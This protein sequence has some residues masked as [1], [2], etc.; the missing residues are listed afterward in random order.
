MDQRVT[1]ITFGVSDVARAR[2]F[3][4]RIGWKASSESNAFV[5]FFQA[6]TTVFGLFGQEMLSEES[7]ISGVPRP[8]GVSLACNMRSREEVDATMA[9]VEAAG[10]TI[11]RPA[12]ETAWGGYVG[13]FTDP[14]GHAWEVTHAPMLELS[15]DGFL[16]MPD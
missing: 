7:G 11:T 9:E 2:A 8:G 10:A 13:Y 14:D 4:E 12:G 5:V 15:D 16:V 6:G 3:Y 1:L